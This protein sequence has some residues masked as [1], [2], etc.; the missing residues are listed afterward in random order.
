MPGPAIAPPQRHTVGGRRSGGSCATAARSAA[1]G[2]GLFL[3]VAGEPGIGKTTLV[4]E[5]VADLAAGRTCTVAHG[6]CS[7]RL[8]AAE[9]YLPFLEA[10]ESLLHGQMAR[11]WPAVMK[12]VAPTWY[13]QLGAAGRRGF[14][15]LP[16]C[17]R[18]QRCLAGAPQT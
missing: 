6:R 3:C 4:E 7:E 11:R 12:V 5:F 17:G 18:M 16:A 2:R 14:L 15:A 10:L 1:A 8:A 9:A 13:V